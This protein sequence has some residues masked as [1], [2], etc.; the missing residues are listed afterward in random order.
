VYIHQ[1]RK[2]LISRPDCN[3]SNQDIFDGPLGKLKKSYAV[4]FIFENFGFIMC[5]IV[6]VWRQLP[7]SNQ[8]SLFYTL[9]GFSGG[10]LDLNFT[11]GCQN[12][13]VKIFSTFQNNRKNNKLGKTMNVYA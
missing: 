4:K 12:S 10:K 3:G 7:K 8:N 6:L 5:V 11:F 1:I 2:H 13:K 9:S